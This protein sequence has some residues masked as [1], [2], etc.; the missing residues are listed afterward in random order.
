MKKKWVILVFIAIFCCSLLSV[1]IQQSSTKAEGT[2]TM[3]DHLLFSLDFEDDDNLGLDSSGNNKNAVNSNV[4]QVN[5]PVRGK[6]GQFK[7]ADQS[8]LKIDETLILNDNLAIAFWVRQSDPPAWAHIFDFSATTAPGVGWAGSPTEQHHFYMVANNIHQSWS[9][10]SVQLRQHS[11]VANAEMEIN[12]GGV[13]LPPGTANMHLGT[14]SH[15]V[16]TIGPSAAADTDI[17]TLYINGTKVDSKQMRKGVHMSQAV[18]LE[19][20][21]IGKSNFPDDPYYQG[22]LDDFRIY[23]YCPNE[24][25]IAQEFQYDFNQHLVLEYTFDSTNAGANN[26]IVDSSPYERTPESGKTKTDGGAT[27]NSSIKGTGVS[28]SDI[29]VQGKSA[30]FDGTNDSFILL[31]AGMAFGMHETTV[32]FY[33]KAEEI[34]SMAGFFGFGNYDGLRYF[35]L[36]SQG[37]VNDG[38]TANLKTEV[39]SGVTAANTLVNIGGSTESPAVIDA[40]IW[41][42]FAVT[43]D[44]GAL[45]LYING[46]LIAEHTDMKFT[47]A[48]LHYSAHNTIGRAPENSV[49][50]KGWIDE[51]KVYNIALTQEEISTLIFMPEITADTSIEGVADITGAGYYAVNDEVTL[52]VSNIQA[53]YKFA[54]WEVEGNIVSTTAEYKFPSERS[55][56]VTAKIIETDEVYIRIADVAV[57][58]SA[59]GKGVYGIGDTVQ[60]NATVVPGYSFE[61]WY[62]GSTLLSSNANYSF[63]LTSEHTANAILDITAQIAPKPTCVVTAA[64]NIDAG[65]TITGAASYLK[66]QEVTLTATLAT[67]Y[68]FLNWTVNGTEVGTSLTYSFECAANVTVTANFEILKFTVTATAGTGGT[69]TATATYDYGSNATYTFTPDDDYA[70]KK[71]LVDGEEVLYSNNKYTFISLTENH[72]ISVEFQKTT[73]DIVSTGGCSCKSAAEING[74]SA[75]LIL[76]VLASVIAIITVRK[77]KKDC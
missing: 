27:S 14:W 77:S 30:Y 35:S 22:M 52:N 2:E 4:E 21:Y 23:S 50:Y 38:V 37:S 48:T 26:L 58:G 15:V 28:Q 33:A 59:T 32:A 68:K 13:P 49:F 47:P 72:V 5:D 1:Q 9:G 71:V 64:K 65:G 34:R 70:I 41:Y 55:I 19:N 56:N 74:N 10:M 24:A 3:S 51:F 16:F 73:D 76:V 12:K 36:S 8:Y 39:A 60:L 6:V 18:N 29:A 40:N 57:G 17:M 54:Y 63:V 25:E 53:G 46:S 7:T 62:K 45:R 69:I 44:S 43:F 42:H 11:K 20:G 66:G 67:G 61:G 75:L 31:P